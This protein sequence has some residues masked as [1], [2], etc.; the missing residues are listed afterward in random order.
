[1]PDCKFK[2]GDRVA[3]I[4]WRGQFS[5]ISRVR[6]VMVRFVE[7]D[8]GG[9]WKLDGNRYPHREHGDYAHIADVTPEHE[10]ADKRRLSVSRLFSTE[11]RNLSDDQLRRVMTIVNEKG[12][13]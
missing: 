8:D 6:R 9:K 5:R 13:Q 4:D 11:W 1:M 10:V 2:V 12:E 3:V 7:L